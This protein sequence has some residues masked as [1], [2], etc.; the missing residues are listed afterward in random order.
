[1]VAALVLAVLLASCQPLP[2]PFAEDRPPREL[3]AIP[4]SAGVSIA[5]V[6]GQPTAIAAR[7]GAATARALL[8]HEIP[9]S[10]KTIGR[11]SYRLYGGITQT[12]GRRGRSAV[13]VLWRLDDATGRRIGER[14]VRIEGTEEEWRSAEGAMIDRLAAL[15]AD[16]VARLFVGVPASP[17]L[18]A[19]V[20]AISGPTEPAAAMPGPPPPKPPVP[21][22]ATV[23]PAI[24][25]PP[26]TQPGSPTEANPSR[27]QENGRIRVALRRVTGAPGDGAASLARAVT[28][29]LRQRTLTIVDPGGKADFYIE[30]EVTITPAGSDKQHVKIV[31]RVRDANGAELGTVGQENDVPRG[32]LSRQWGD[33][34]YAVAAAASDGLMQVLA[35]APPHATP[36]AGTGSAPEPSK[37]APGRRPGGRAARAA[38]AE[39]AKTKGLRR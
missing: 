3:L 27:K 19:M 7:L 18:A 20:P 37:A 35:S 39:A 2:H 32:L 29:V 10:A 9:A 8:G 21:G 14:E 25:A 22:R 13:A 30:G 12:S 34:A 33:V 16:A 15:S 4:E 28:S 24:P 11:G 23:R 38:A 6:E 1:L 31:W 36:A 17:R 26:S 5:P